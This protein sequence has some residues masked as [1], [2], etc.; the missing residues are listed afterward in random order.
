ME[1]SQNKVFIKK[2]LLAQLKNHQNEMLKLEQI[3]SKKW[4]KLP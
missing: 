1:N 3:S 2:N 4:K